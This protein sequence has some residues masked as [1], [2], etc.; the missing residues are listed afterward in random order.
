[1]GHETSVEVL[2]AVGVNLVLAVGLV[3]VLALAAVKAR[4]DLGADTDALAGLGESDLGADTED[5]ADDFV[6]D[7]KR[8]GGVRTPFAVD[9]V[10]VT[11]ADTAGVDLDVDVVVAKGTGLPGVLFKLEELFG[12]GGLE[13]LELVRDRHFEWNWSCCLLA[14]KGGGSEEGDDVEA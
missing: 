10:K 13:A 8:V 3:L 4:V 14:G 11:G 9:L 6:S 12:A 1:M 7:G 5:L 2:S